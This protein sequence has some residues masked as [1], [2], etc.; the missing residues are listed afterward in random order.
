MIYLRMNGIGPVSQGIDKN[1]SRRVVSESPLCEI[2]ER[3]IAKGL[4]RFL[5][6]SSKGPLKKT[7]LLEMTISK[8]VIF[9]LRS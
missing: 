9:L 1:Q 2:I 6:V 4:S 5:D 7:R 8:V 3:P